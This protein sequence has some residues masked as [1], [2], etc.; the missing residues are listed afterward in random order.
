MSYGLYL[1]AAGARAQ[2][3]RLEV[4]SNNLANVDTPGFKRE[5]AV[6]HAR[7]AEA[8]EQGNDYPG[9]GSMNDLGGGVGMRQTVTDFGRGIL[10]KTDALTDVAIK[11]EDGFFLVQKDDQ[12]LLTRAGNFQF[13]REGRLVT[14]QGFPVLAQDGNPI[15][16]NP[17]LP[18]QWSETGEVM[19]G[20]DRIPLAVVKP[21]AL[22][23]LENRGENLFQSR[24]P[25]EPLAGRDRE[26]ASGF[27]E[28]SSV[29]P[30]VEMM[31]L[32]EA[33]RAYEVN[34]RMIQNQDHV[35]G[36]L[37]SRVLRQ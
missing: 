5:L 31:N 26:V 32:I 20:N 15:S 25:L 14:Q 13:T 6:N 29:Q 3:Q 33:S 1:S 11:S 2:S 28:L 24:S 23:D 19:Q 18:W 36:E 22:S 27:L 34:V 21:A 10:K 4:L 35:I 12:Q 16:I 17:Q 30:A 8:I 9:S 37:I 7:H